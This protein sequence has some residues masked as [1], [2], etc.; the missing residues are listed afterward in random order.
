MESRFNTNLA[1]LRMKAKNGE[2]SEEECFD[3]VMMLRR[4]G[5]NAV[6]QACKRAEDAS[7][8][9]QQVRQA[10]VIGC[11][12]SF[13]VV[14]FLCGYDIA[15]IPFA[16]LV[17][18]IVGSI[19]LFIRRSLKRRLQV[20]FKSLRQFDLDWYTAHRSVCRPSATTQD[21]SISKGSVEVFGSASAPKCIDTVCD[22]KSQIRTSRQESIHNLKFE[23]E[24]EPIVSDAE[25]D[26]S[27]DADVVVAASEAKPLRFYREP[28]VI[29]VSPSHNWPEIM[30]V[31][32]VGSG[33]DWWD[34]VFSVTE[35][36]AVHVF[37]V[38]NYLQFRAMNSG[39]LQQC[40][41]E[42]CYVLYNIDKNKAYVGQSG[43]VPSRVYAHLTGGGCS[44]IQQAFHAG[45]IIEICMI[46]KSDTRYAS[47]FD[48]NRFERELIAAYDAYDN[49]YNLTRG[50][51]PE[52]SGR[53]GDS[54]AW[55]FGEE[56]CTASAF[57]R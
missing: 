42:G 22:V 51:N 10:M 30:G 11:V 53:Y 43:K 52:R 20:D 27:D 24:N 55:S 38:E 13:I 1:R 35:A 48:L 28:E 29:K 54:I 23:C 14:F 31:T 18:D 19:F 5:I 34:T 56:R 16:F 33:L 7:V 8:Q 47:D 41:F 39:R 40:E 49:G 12:S 9:L 26:I 57:R 4:V 25:V 50:N 45:D 6:L 17:A 3:Y 2:L 32:P 44:F 21:V 46:D 36:S 15:S 37:D